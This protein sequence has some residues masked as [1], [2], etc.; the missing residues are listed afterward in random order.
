MNVLYIV[1]AFF[2]GV[3]VGSAIALIFY[4]RTKRGRLL[5]QY[6]ESFPNANETAVAAA[7]SILKNNIMYGNSLDTMKSWGLNDEIIYKG[8]MRSNRYAI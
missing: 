7:I 3:S 1:S 4:N 8:K 2:A 6:T 5:A